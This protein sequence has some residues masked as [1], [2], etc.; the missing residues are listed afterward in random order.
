VARLIEGNQEFEL[1]DVHDQ[2]DRLPA[3]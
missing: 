1:F 3:A 2:A